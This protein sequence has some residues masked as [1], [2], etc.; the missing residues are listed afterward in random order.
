LLLSLVAFLTAAMITLLVF[1]RFREKIMKQLAIK[2][3]EA[4]S[5]ERLKAEFL[6][7]VSHEL[8]TPLNG[9][10]GLSDILTRTHADADTRFKTGVI[11]ESGHRLLSVVEA[12]T[13]MAQLDAHKMQLFAEP[14][15][16]SDVLAAPIET[17]RG[18]AADKALTF[19][20]YVD[21]DLGTHDVDGLRLGQCVGYLL[22]NAVK[23]TDAGR[24]HV[25]VTAVREESDA[26]SGMQIVVADT[27][28]GMTDL[29]HSRLFTPFMQADTSMSRK[30]EG[31]GLSLAITRAL[32]RMMGGDVTVTTK[33]GRGTEFVMDVR[34]GVI[35]SAEE[36]LSRTRSERAFRTRVGDKFLLAQEDKAKQKA[37]K[38]AKKRAAQ[39]ERAE[40]AELRQRGKAK[41]IV[42]S[43][44]ALPIVTRAKACGTASKPVSKR[45]A[46]KAAAKARVQTRLASVAAENTSAA[47]GLIEPIE[48]LKA[49]LATLIETP[50]ADIETPASAAQNL[51]AQKLEPFQTASDDIEI[52]APVRDGAAFSDV[53]PII[54][55]A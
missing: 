42:E 38:R 46:R 45:K 24:V 17:A 2:T 48:A 34:F 28:I 1:L 21:P 36:A 35:F 31:A 30:F 14:T 49:E 4:A 5:A 13:D 47:D 40:K 10:I 44:A 55:F 15:I 29:I 37:E 19:T 43:D 20:T 54:S 25:H 26:V 18:R 41:N 22:S 33:Q 27:G 39:A 23:F 51:D 6:G 53:L 3:R 11:L 16:I 7:L 12:M 8:R 50:E 9:V 32:A 52:A